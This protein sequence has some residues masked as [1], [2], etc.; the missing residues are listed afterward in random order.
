MMDPNSLQDLVQKRSASEAE[1]ARLENEIKTLDADIARH[2]LTDAAF[3]IWQD[4]MSDRS[5]GS[6]SSD[7]LQSLFMG[8]LSRRVK[9]PAARVVLG[10]PNAEAARALETMEDEADVEK[11]EEAVEA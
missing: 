1:R 5:N 3:D 2:F 11:I 4:F 10:L 6:G 9:D 7:S 8:Y